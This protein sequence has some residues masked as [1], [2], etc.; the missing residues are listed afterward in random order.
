MKAAII[1]NG[2]GITLKNGKKFWLP[3]D[4]AR[5]F[6]RWLIEY[7]LDIWQIIDAQERAKEVKEPPEM[8]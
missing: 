4:E 6:K 5:E 2:I 3:A 8:R 1:A 7:D